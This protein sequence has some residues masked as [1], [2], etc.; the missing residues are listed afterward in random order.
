MPAVSLSIMIQ[1]K[2]DWT[3]ILQR[4]DFDDIWIRFG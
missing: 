3:G 1:I 2:N 4:I